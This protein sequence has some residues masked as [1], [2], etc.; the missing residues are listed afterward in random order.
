MEFESKTSL[1]SG[2]GFGVVRKYE[3]EKDIC[4]GEKK[5]KV[6]IVTDV[7]LNAKDTMKFNWSEIAGIITTKGTKN[8]HSSIIAK[9]HGVPA[10][11]ISDISELKDGDFIAL[12]SYSME[13]GKVYY[14][15]SKEDVEELLKKLEDLN[16]KKENLKKYKLVD[17]NLEDGYKPILAANIGT[18]EELAGVNQNCAE[19]IG[20]VR[21][22]FI[23]E[24]YD[25][26]KRKLP[27]EEEQYNEYK[28]ISEELKG[29]PVI[30][31]TLDAGADK[32]VESL[33]LAGV[34]KKE[35]ANPALG[36]RGVRPCLKNL[37]LFK[38]QIRAILRA[39]AKNNNLQI[40]FPMITS[41]GEFKKC[42]EIV[43]KAIEELKKEN[44][45]FEETKIGIMV[46][47]PAIAQI[48][49]RLSSNDCDFISV[50]TNDLT[51]YMTA[52]DRT[53]NE[54]ENIATPYNPGMVR[55]LKNIISEAHRGK[56][57]IPVGVCGEIAGDLEYIP[58][59]L[60]MGL[61][62]FSMNSSNILEAR[63]LISNLTLNECKVL[64]DEVLEKD[65]ELEIESIVK[66]FYKEHN[67]KILSQEEMERKAELGEV[68]QKEA[69]AK[70]LKEKYYSLVKEELPSYLEGDDR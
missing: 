17:I 2:I 28:K 41:I 3:R 37:K 38:T 10:I 62:E 50:G 67:L 43:D 16:I 31:R 6:I 13:N 69:E 48:T 14:K 12:D 52:A 51:Q 39:N 44:A 23:Y 29:K 18:T 34:L 47:T 40:M 65:S 64:L 8:S 19:G 57:P 25:I 11:L 26:T 9:Q 30:I 45:E 33:I 46:E 21:T 66:N 1:S 54:V 49:D 22:E 7:D 58:L 5:K 20:V 63:R 42:K 68:L 32:Q 4:Y 70:N 36:S 60:A 35:E 56:K 27:T 55:I 15:P 61:D 24:M 53:N 59:L